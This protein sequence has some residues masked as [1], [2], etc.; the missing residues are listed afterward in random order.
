M[1]HRGLEKLAAVQHAIWAHWMRYLFRV[2]VEGDDGSCTI[3]AEAVRRWKRQVATAYWDLPER[4]RASDRDQADKVIVALAEVADVYLDGLDA[5]QR[6]RAA[7]EL[8]KFVD[9][10]KQE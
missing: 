3:P 1:Q 4:E 7:E 9:W 2:A 5:A 10:L 6:P 8:G